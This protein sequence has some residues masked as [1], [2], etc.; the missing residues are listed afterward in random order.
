MR[1]MTQQISFRLSAG[2]QQTIELAALSMGISVAE[3]A[4]VC[5]TEAAKTVAR[6]LREG[7]RFIPSP[8]LPNLPK[9]TETEKAE[10]CFKTA[11]KAFRQTR[12]R[13]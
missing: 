12:I 4:R 7:E 1:P 5:T 11:I 3:F 9:E 2:D 13:A 8:E 10:R 6:K